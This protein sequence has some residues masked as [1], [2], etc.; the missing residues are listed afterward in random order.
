MLKTITENRACC[1]IY[2]DLSHSMFTKIIG[3]TVTLKQNIKHKSI[4][5][6]EFFRKVGN[7]TIL[8]I[9]FS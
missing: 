5:N 8:N 1:S 2:I 3:G 7:T 9:S 6:S 4:K